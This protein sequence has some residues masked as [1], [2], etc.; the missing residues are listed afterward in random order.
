MP[1]G[2][3]G[4]A[5]SVWPTRDK[6]G[7]SGGHV[8]PLGPGAAEAGCGGRLAVEEAVAEEEGGAGGLEKSSAGWRLPMVN[9]AEHLLLPP[10]SEAA[11]S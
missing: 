2:G 5:S 10:P 1:G 7:A 9:C 3:G 8:L 6:R 11:S 4:G